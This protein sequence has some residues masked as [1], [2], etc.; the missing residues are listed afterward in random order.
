MIIT[1]YYWILE[2]PNRNPDQSAVADLYGDFVHSLPLAFLL[3]DFVFL[4]SLPFLIRH[5][6]FN[7]VIKLSYLILNL[8]VSLSSE[9]IYK[10]I[11]WRSPLGI[12]LPLCLIL[13]AFLLHLGFRKLSIWKLQYLK[14]DDAVTVIQSEPWCTCAKQEVSKV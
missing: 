3:F 9:P 8:S 7:L 12:A 5:E 13:V 6:V 11:S 4:N 10:L 1:G 14:Q 2:Y